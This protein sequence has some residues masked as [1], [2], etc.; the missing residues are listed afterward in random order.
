M[1][2]DLNLELS[3]IIRLYELRFKIEFGFKQ[4][5]QVIGAFDYH[6]CICLA[7]LWGKVSCSTSLYVILSVPGEPLANGSGQSDKAF[8]PS[9]RI[10]AMAL[11]NCLPH[12][13]V[14][15]A[16]TSN[17]A[18]FIIENEDPDRV[19]NLGNAAQEPV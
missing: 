19:S 8:P 3:E 16:Q 6:F 17:L 15:N 1:S 14:D 4:V 2:T 9:E 10:V 11:R 13:L 12:F 7:A 5:S 18:K